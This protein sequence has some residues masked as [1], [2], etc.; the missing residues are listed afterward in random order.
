MLIRLQFL[1]TSIN[2]SLTTVVKKQVETN[3]YFILMSMEILIK[4]S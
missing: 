3:Q 1:R 4:S 2:H